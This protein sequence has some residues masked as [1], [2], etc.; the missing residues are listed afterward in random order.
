MNLL[1]NIPEFDE[2][3]SDIIQSKTNYNSCNMRP[4]EQPNLRNNNNNPTTITN[5]SYISSSSIANTS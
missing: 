1:N 5:V 3:Y 4:L 2:F